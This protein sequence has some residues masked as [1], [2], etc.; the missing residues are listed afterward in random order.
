MN[1]FENAAQK[2]Q[3]EIDGLIMGEFGVV[4]SGRATAT[5]QEQ[6][7]RDLIVRETP[8]CLQSR[9]L[10]E[11]MGCGP[12]KPLLEDETLT[13]IIVNGPFQIWYEK[14][15]T[16]LAHD[17]RFTS[18]LTYTNFLERVCLEAQIQVTLDQ[19]TADGKWLNFRLHIS[20]S[21]L[22][23]EHTVL[24]LRRHPKIPWNFEKLEAQGWC[25]DE[26][27]RLFEEIVARRENFLIV[28]STGSG[29]TSVLNAC[30]QLLEPNQ[31]VVAIEDSDELILPNQVSTKLLTREDPF[32]VL[33]TID[34]S[35]LVKQALRMR[36]D[37]I[38]M[39]EVR[40]VE[41]K[42]FL[43]ALSTGHQGSMG[44]LHASHPRQA[45]IRLEMLIQMGAPHWALSAIRQLIFLSL[46]HIII[47]GRD[48]EKK[49]VLQGIYEISS[50]EDTG[51][52]IERLF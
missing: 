35:F 24:C 47:T 12:L 49:R 8:I 29:K 48:K 23:K 37:R 27:R 44:T 18:L 6:K 51:F 13:E 46:K 16:L 34:Q 26:G 52:L 2:I 3:L 45:L 10:E 19:P 11:F 32:G 38:V 41:A 4:G 20:G 5:E 40:G 31:R 21:Y 28:G 14:S 33:R 36:P 42:D 17:D 7:I 39:G 1:N 30:L 9:M 22:T 50:L 25:S 15:G 43:M